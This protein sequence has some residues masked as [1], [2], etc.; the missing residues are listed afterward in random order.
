MVVAELKLA[1]GSFDG[2]PTQ[3]MRASSRLAPRDGFGLM[4]T[5]MAKLPTYFA[6]TFLSQTAFA[7]WPIL[8]F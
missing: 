2:L 7:R 1:K 3:L 5:I 8:I 4:S 6:P